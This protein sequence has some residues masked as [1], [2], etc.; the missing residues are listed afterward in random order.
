MNIS[1]SYFSD[2]KSVQRN[3]FQQVLVIE[4]GKK[5]KTQHHRLVLEILSL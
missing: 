4:C 5:M 1:P 3:Y 2:M